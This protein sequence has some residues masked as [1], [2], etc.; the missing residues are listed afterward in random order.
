MQT[1]ITFALCYNTCV[2][3]ESGFLSDGSPAHYLFL[4]SAPGQSGLL[5]SLLSIGYALMVAPMAY[6]HIHN[7]SRCTLFSKLPN[8]C[9]TT[10]ADTAASFSIHC[11]RVIV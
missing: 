9:A 2:T 1:E 7:P 8:M 11:Y 10:R 3:L 6:P 5:L 4:V